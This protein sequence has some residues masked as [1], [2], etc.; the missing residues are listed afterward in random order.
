MTFNS[1]KELVLS[2]PRIVLNTVEKAE[3]GRIAI[4]V[5]IEKVKVLI[6]E[7][8]EDDVCECLEKLKA[9]LEGK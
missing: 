2:D 4:N 3:V 5:T 8:D 1:I 9:R 7:I 6:D